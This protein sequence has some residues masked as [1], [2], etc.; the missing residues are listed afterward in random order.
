MLLQQVREIVEAF[1]L[2]NCQRGLARRISDLRVC[3]VRQQRLDALK[4]VFVHRLHQRRPAVII[5]RINIR[6]DA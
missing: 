3:A 6:S 1:V 4:I 5:F 2:G